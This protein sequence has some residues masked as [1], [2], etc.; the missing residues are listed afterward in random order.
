MKSVELLPVVG[1]ESVN[2]TLAASVVESIVESSE[3]V[4]E[5]TKVSIT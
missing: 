4:V 5:L 3:A 2:S 1:E